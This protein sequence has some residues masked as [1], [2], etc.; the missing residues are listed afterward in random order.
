MSDIGMVFDTTTKIRTPFKD[1]DCMKDYNMLRLDS[2]DNYSKV[3]CC[4]DEKKT[5]QLSVPNS[6]ASQVV[7]VKKEK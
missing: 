4:N 2:K 7:C 5:Y 6:E 3:K 1:T